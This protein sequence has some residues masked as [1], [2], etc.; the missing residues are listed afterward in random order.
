MIASP[1]TARDVQQNTQ[2]GPRHEELKMF[3]VS[4]ATTPET[5]LEGQ[6]QTSQVQEAGESLLK[7][8][9]YLAQTVEIGDGVTICLQFI[10]GQ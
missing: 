3:T 2:V 4:D 7:G 9:N 10:E 5:S 1:H 8:K 6:G